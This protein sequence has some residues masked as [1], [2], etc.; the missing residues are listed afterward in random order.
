MRFVLMFLLVAIFFGA[1][2]KAAT[3]TFDFRLPCRSEGCQIKY[4]SKNANVTI[5]INNSTFAPWQRFGR[6]ALSDFSVVSGNYKFDLR[7]AL[8][9]SVDGIWARRPAGRPS[10]WIEASVNPRGSA[11]F[12][13]GKTVFFANTFYR[14][15]SLNA[16]LAGTTTSI[17]DYEAYGISHP[18]P[19]PMPAV[20][21]AFGISIL[22]LG[23]RVFSSS[24]SHA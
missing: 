6:E 19:L 17:A 1:P 10:I 18:I 13:P 15:I 11:N 9:L 14:G 16:G 21:L 20:L 22:A 23:K 4:G 7:E 12:E 2:A 5:T 8:D 3:V 24:A